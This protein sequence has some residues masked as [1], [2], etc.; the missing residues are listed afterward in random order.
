MGQNT[1]FPQMN[2]VE[3]IFLGL[4]KSNWEDLGGE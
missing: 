2:T 4:G 3:A 1:H